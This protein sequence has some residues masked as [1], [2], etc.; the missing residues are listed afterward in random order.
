[1][2]DAIS[3]L[4]L[5]PAAQAADLMANKVLRGRGDAAKNAPNQEQAVQAAKDF[6][7]VLL[8]RLLS[9]MRNTIPDSGLLGD[10]TS[11]QVESMFWMFLSQSLSEKGGIGLSKQLTRDFMKMAN[12]SQPAQEPKTECLK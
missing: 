8:H 9:E 3:G 4:P 1:M 6:E 5:N 2:S 7:S 11:D 12:L 10:G